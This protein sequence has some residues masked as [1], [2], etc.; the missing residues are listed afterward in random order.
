[1]QRTKVLHIAEAFGGGVYTMVSS[2]LCRTCD[3]FDTY[4][5]Y[6]L[7]PQTPEDYRAQLDSRIHIMEMQH[8]ERKIGWKDLLNY[9][10]IRRAVRKAVS[11][12][13]LDVYKRQTPRYLRREADLF[14]ADIAMLVPSMIDFLFQEEEIMPRLY[15]VILRCV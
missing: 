12:T 9:A 13:H 4:L 3:E 8:A 14:D 7:R 10:E 11:Y 2:L 1:M 6:A 5:L 15:A